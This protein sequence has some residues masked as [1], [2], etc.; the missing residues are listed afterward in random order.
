MSDSATPILN[1]KTMRKGEPQLDWQLSTIAFLTPG[2]THLIWQYFFLVV[3]EAQMTISITVQTKRIVTGMET[4][5]KR[6]KF[7]VVTLSQETFQVKMVMNLRMMTMTKST[8][9]M[10][11]CLDITNCERYYFCCE[12]VSCS[13]LYREFIDL[14]PIFR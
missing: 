2:D 14:F 3:M 6:R 9:R 10:R 8:R 4:S 5:I 13:C 1:A 11:T 7:I 12:V